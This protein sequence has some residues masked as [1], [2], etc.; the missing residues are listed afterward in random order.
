MRR[1]PSFFFGTF[2]LLVVLIILTLAAFSVLSYVTAN[3]DYQLTKKAADSVSDYYDADANAQVRIAYIDQ[4][5]K[6]PNWKNLL[7]SNGYN[8]RQTSSGTLVSFDVSAGES[9]TLHVELFV[10]PGQNPT[11]ERHVWNIEINPK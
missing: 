2:S 3:N 4:T 6:D 9:R 1:R 7:I 11:I 8:V 10:V 5:L